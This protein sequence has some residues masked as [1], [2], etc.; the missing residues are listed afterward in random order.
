MKQQCQGTV[1]SVFLRLPWPMHGPLPSSLWSL[2]RDGQL[3]KRRQTRAQGSSSCL[4]ADG[5][6]LISIASGFPVSPSPVLAVCSRQAW[7]S[8]LPLLLLLCWDYTG[9]PPCLAF[10]FLKKK[11]LTVEVWGSLPLHRQKSLGHLIPYIFL[12][13]MLNSLKYLT[14]S[15]EFIPDNWR[16]CVFGQNT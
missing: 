1:A 3:I 10:L 11:N 9:V 15:C 5:S 14:E 6:Q 7:N 4:P 12:Y 8:G 13:L 16:G 2:E